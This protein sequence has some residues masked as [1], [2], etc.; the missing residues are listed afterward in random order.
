MLEL[1]LVVSERSPMADNLCAVVNSDGM[2]ARLVS[3]AEALAGWRAGDRTPD[4]LL[5]NAAL[6][7]SIVRQLAQRITRTT[8]RPP[9]VVMFAERDFRE[10]EEH[11]MA[12]LD[13][14][15]PP[16]LPG[17]IG[18]RLVACHVRQVMS[19]TTQDIQTAVIYDHFTPF[20]LTQ[21]EEFGFCGRGEARDFIRDGAIH[22]A[23][24]L[25]LNTHGGPVM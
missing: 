13:Y 22:L 16:F 12:G 2:P 19:R 4:L 21:L 7:L 5:V 10:L 6:N 20:V 9:T 23:G 18:S 17:L 1:T 14:I 11:V 3:P 24:R 15:I 8:S 25:P